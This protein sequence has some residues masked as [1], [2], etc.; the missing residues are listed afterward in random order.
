MSPIQLFEL[1]LL[2]AIWGASFLFMRIAAPLFGVIVAFFWLNE[3]L[4]LARG[5]G[6]V[7]G[8]T[9]VVI[10]IGWENGSGAGLPVT[11]VAAA[12]LAAIFY[13]FG[14][15]YAR[16][17]LGAAAPLTVAA[18]S[19]LGAALFL[20]P[21]VP[22]STPANS[23]SLTVLLVALALAVLSTAVAYI[24][25][26]H[27]I[28]NAGSSKALTVTYLVLLFAMGLHVPLRAD[29]PGDDCRL[30]ADS[31]RDG[32]GQRAVRSAIPQISG[33][34]VRVLAT[35]KQKT[36]RLAYKSQPADIRVKK[37]KRISSFG[38]LFA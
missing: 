18:G 16:L 31:D 34:S 4:S 37:K 8:F 28:Q 7:L 36:N 12:L 2:A 27:L 15:P 32:R 22:F 6:F 23:P 33:G 11:A 29:H 19:Q 5:V 1:F 13:A 26:F 14:A 9:G 20:L 17:K 21:A 38:G 30:H 25:Y 10:L 35:E 24:L 3:R